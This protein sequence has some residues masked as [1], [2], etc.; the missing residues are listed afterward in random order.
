MDEI[1]EDQS[2]DHIA[3]AGAARSPRLARRGLRHLLL[4]S[5]AGAA[6]AVVALAAWGTAYE[7]V[8]SIGDAAAFPPGG[9]LIEVGGSR[10]HL[11]CRGEGSPTV[12]LDAGLGGS[13]LDWSLV[14]PEVATTSRVCSYDR[15][16]MGRSDSSPL[17]RD[18][19]RL[20]GELHA[21]LEAAGVPGP[22]VLVGHSLA[23]KTVRLFAAAHPDEVAGMVL[24]DARSEYVDALVSPAEAEGFAA[25]LKT[26]GLVYSM[27]RRLGVARAFAAQLIG[28]DTLPNAIATE[29]VLQKTAA[30]AIDATTA[31]GT[32]RAD[33]DAALAGTTLGTLPLVVVAADTSLADL[34]NW[35]AAQERMA[36]LSSNGKLVVA[37]HSSHDVQLEKP[38]IVIDAIRAVVSDVR[39]EL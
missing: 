6:I 3:S 31:E 2:L 27:A 12:V 24:V 36:A 30:G 39:N 29:M 34:P 17:P 11:D 15:A 20:A 8:A 25:A 21:L 7:A 16:G 35:Q 22:Y 18:P 33:A 9:R 28:L 19:A 13:S 5:V 37:E 23:G 14:Q 26:Q 38:A 4:R 1:A 32:A 10:M